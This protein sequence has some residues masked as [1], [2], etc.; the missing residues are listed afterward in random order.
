MGEPFPNPADSQ[1]ATLFA[2]FKFTVSLVNVNA[3]L[4]FSAIV[5]SDMTCVSMNPATRF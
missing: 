2:P 5:Y 4:A 1:N 3:L